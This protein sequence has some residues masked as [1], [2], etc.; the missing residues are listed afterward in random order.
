MCRKLSQLSADD[1]G[2]WGTEFGWQIK[3]ADR[4]TGIKLA[5]GPSVAQRASHT[6]HANDEGVVSVPDTAGL[7]TRAADGLSLVAESRGATDTRR[8][9]GVAA[10]NPSSYIKYS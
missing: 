8:Q 5:R 7:R 1:E 3:G 4:H 2:V 10:L 9:S 6:G